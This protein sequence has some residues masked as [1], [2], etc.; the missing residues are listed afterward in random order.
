MYVFDAY[1]KFEERVVK[2]FLEMMGANKEDVD[3]DGAD[4][5]D[6]N[7]DWGGKAK[8]KSKSENTVVDDEVMDLLLA[9]NAA[10]KKSAGASAD[11]NFAWP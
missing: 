6:D 8:S 9:V 11:V 7:E 3:G 1:F 5:M 10:N 4:R 2:V